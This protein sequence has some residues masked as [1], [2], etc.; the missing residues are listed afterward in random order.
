FAITTRSGVSTQ[1][2]PF[3][4]PPRPTSDDL[5]E[6]EIEKERLE[7]EEPSII[8][9]PSPR[10]SIFYQP[11]KSSNF[12]FPRRLKKQ[13]KDNEDE[14]LLSIFKQIHINLSF[15]EAMIHMPKGAKVLKDLLSHKEKLKK[16]TSFVKLS[17][18]CSAIIQRSL[19][20]KEGDPGSFILPYLIGPLAV[21]NALADLR[22]SINIM[23]HSLF[24][25]SGISKHKPTKMS[26]QLADRSIKY[27]IGVCENLLVKISKFIFPVDFVVLETDEDELV[28]IIFG[29]PF[30][31]TSRAVIDVH[32][33]KLSLR[34]R[35]EI[36]TFNIGK[37]MKSKHSRN[38]YLR[39]GRFQQSA[40]SFLLPKDG[41]GRA[42]RVEVL[43]EPENKQIPVVIS[44]ALS[45]VEKSKLLEVLKNHKG[46]ISWSITDIKGID[47]SFC[48]HKIIIE[49][50]FKP[51][52]QHQ[53]QV[54]P[55]INENANPPPTNNHPVLPAALR[56]RVVQELHELQTTHLKNAISRFTQRFEETF[57]EACERFKE[58]LRACPHHGFSELTQI[59]TFYNGLNEQDQDSL[60]AVVGGNLLIEIVNKQI[61]TPA[62]VKAVEK[63]CV[64]C[65]GAHSY[66]DCIATD[67][68]QSSVCA[69]TGTYNQVSPPNRASNQMVPPSFAPV[70]NNQNR[71]LALGWHFEKI[72]V[73]LAH[74]EKKHARLRDYTK[75]HQEVLFLEHRHG[76]AGIKRRR[77]DLSGDSV[78]ILATV[79]QCSQL[80]MSRDVLTVG[81]TMRIPVLYRGEYSQWVE[82]FMN[83]LEEQTDGEAM[84]NSIKNGDQ[85]LPR[86]TQVSIAGTTSTEQPPLKDKSM[87]SD[88]EKRV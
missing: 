56:M 57:G 49:D 12:P 26:I 25:R 28:L 24:R 68:N 54:N 80:K 61:I 44:S 9:E 18:E 59:D 62:T 10:P 31:A 14:R 42:T 58:M 77:D 27:P 15:L 74:L 39:K 47:S 63:S 48:T 4:A 32:E 21:K 35:S 46:E 55:N 85:P 84:I 50:E 87:W 69:A 76:I 36:V 86:V 45:T 78:W 82:R 70:Q 2:P 7:G 72:Y 11:S 20:Q 75:I 33:G 67:S 30:L 43:E 52:V 51:S 3:P 38:D 6:R 17:K 5:T 88:Q 81:S 41:A 71:F 53:R 34:V 83:Y 73:T 23:P 8:Q 13:K 29:R 40:S 65:G 60:N 64:I 37:S 16:A 22:A 79:S 19:P 66:Y 1:D